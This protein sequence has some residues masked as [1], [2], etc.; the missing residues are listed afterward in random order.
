MGWTGQGII[1]GEVNSCTDEVL[2]GRKK[3][4]TCKHCSVYTYKP[5]GH[6]EIVIG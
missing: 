6:Y 5:S 3:Q 2:V 4:D 1:Y